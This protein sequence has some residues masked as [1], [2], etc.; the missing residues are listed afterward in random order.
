M[1][2]APP[3]NR[4]SLYQR[5]TASVP[6]MVTVIVHIVLVAVAG[7]FVV[8]EQIIGKKKIME[9]A[10]PAETSIAQKQVEHRLQVARK[11]GGSASSSPV[12]ATR[13]FSTAENALQLP[14]MPDL[15]SVGASSLGGMGFGKGIGGVGGGSG[16]NTGVGNGTGIG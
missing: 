7:Y 10:P 4:K 3:K 14:A 16:Y 9:A 5:V 13:I 11:G 12:S 1:S 2:E 15:P 6:L 8:S